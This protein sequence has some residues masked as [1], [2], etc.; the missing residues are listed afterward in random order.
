M[1]WTCDNPGECIGNVQNALFCRASLKT[2]IFMIM[3]QAE[4]QDQ[5]IQDHL[6]YHYQSFL[7]SDNSLQI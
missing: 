7:M 2:L 3:W 1:I 6:F 5:E 4:K